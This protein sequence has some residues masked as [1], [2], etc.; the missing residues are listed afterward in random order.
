MNNHNDE[1]FKD[2][3]VYKETVYFHFTLEVKAGIPALHVTLGIDYA[4]IFPTEHKIIAVTS[5]TLFEQN[6]YAC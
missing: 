3:F 2:S 4:R 1:S 5:D 6:I